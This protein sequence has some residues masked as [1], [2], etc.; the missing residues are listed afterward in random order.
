MK[1]RFS[2]LALLGVTAYLAVAAAGLIYPLSIWNTLSFCLWIAVLAALAIE[3]ANSNSG[4]STFARG[5]LATCLIYV[6]VATLYEGRDYVDE[7]FLDS[8]K[9]AM[10]HYAIL[11][12][13]P[14]PRWEY[15]DYGELNLKLYRCGVANAS[16][17]FGLLGGSLAL[18]R[19]RVLQRRPKEQADGVAMECRLQN[20]SDE[21]LSDLRVQMCAMLKGLEGFAEQTNDNKLFRGD[22]ACCRSP[23][24]QR[25][26]IM[27]WT[28][29]QRTWGNAPCPCL[30]SDPQFPDCPP[31]ETVTARGRLWFYE[32][33]AIEEKLRK[34]EELKWRE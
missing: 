17:N 7:R 34:L 3:G 14:E 25:W 20:R 23:D 28:P 27:A 32:G 9:R 24:G 33:D 10:P 6:A 12:M 13:S 5:M 30:H 22:Y 16:F 4:G 21:T 29:N 11:L 8:E 31:G 15:E 18:W 26:V 1:P 19:Y 2:I